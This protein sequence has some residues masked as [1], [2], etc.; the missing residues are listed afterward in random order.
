MLADLVRQRRE[1][2]LA[3]ARQRL[4][5]LMPEHT[6]QQAQEE[7]PSL[8]DHLLVDLSGPA[9]QKDPKGAEVATEH[10]RRRQRLGVEI[11]FVV[12][13]F[14]VL[15]DAIAIIAGRAGARIDA[16]DWLRLN[17]S[18]DLGIATAI[19]GYEE[20]R[21]MQERQSTAVEIGGVAHELRNALAAASTAFEAIKRGRVGGASRTS[22]I[23]TRNLSRAAL[24]TSDLLLGS[25][26][27]AGR[28]LAPSAVP[29]RPLIDEVV[30]GISTPGG[31]PFRIEAGADLEIVADRDLL[32]SALTNLV[33]NAAKFT[34]P[35]GKVTVRA[36]RNDQATIVEVEDECGG[37]PPGSTEALFAPFEQRGSNRTGAGLGL[38]IVHKIM[39]AHHGSVRVRDLPGHGCAFEL[40]FTHRA[41]E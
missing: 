37:L 16:A 18:L 19:S 8:L 33:Q 25:R 26:L 1:E 32:T 15:C 24:L 3:F 12:H 10:G 4:T 23:V 14:G 2:V 41:P 22:E 9:D 5:E 36:R 6:V 34:P 21:Q 30:G 7:L 39:L 40:H 29:L 28:G 11:Q 35:G 38:S 17:R 27:Q 20:R 13:D 31:P